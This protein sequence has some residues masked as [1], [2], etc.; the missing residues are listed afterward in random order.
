MDAS[1]ANKQVNSP[2]VTKLPPPEGQLVVNQTIIRPIDRQ[3]K[4]IGYWRMGHIAA[5]RVIYPNRVRL[6]DLYAD[7]EL[8]GHLKGVWKKRVSGV[9]NKKLHYH[10]AEG[11]VVEEMDKVI[12]SSPFRK[13]IRELMK[14]KSHGITGME[15]IPGSKFAWKKIN[16]KHIKPETGIIAIEQFG[17]EGYDYNQLP[18]VWVVGDPD[19][20][21]FLLE[22][23]PYALYKRGTLADWSQFSEI[24][25]MPI[26]VV[27]YD[28]ND[29]KTKIELKTVLDDSGSALVLMVPKQAE[30]EIIDGKTTNA[31]GSIYS[32]FK[33]CCNQ[34]MSVV[35]LGVTETT[36]ASNTSGYAQSKVHSDQQMEITKE[37]LEDMETLLNEDKFLSILQSY[38]LP[39]GNGGSFKYE[40]EVNLDNL[41]KRIVVDMQVAKKV[42]V[43]DDYFYDTYGIPKPDNYNELKKKMD[44]ERVIPGADPGT[45]DPR[46]EDEDDPGGDSPQMSRWNQLRLVLA[47]FFGPARAD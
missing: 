10:D 22:C 14:E 1:Q 3:V 34:E 44:Q 6:Y 5:E 21:G 35:V 7:V 41:S 46:L 12:K 23:A 37:D 26:R 42:P 17:T 27:K 19:N 31:D 24:F 2:E 11:H 13:M 8:D 38:N 20:Y 39:V 9:L 25:G 40:E 15:F 4:D 28:T 45:E 43:S 36:T 16:R 47:N 33:E 30:F 18:L 32:N 29:L